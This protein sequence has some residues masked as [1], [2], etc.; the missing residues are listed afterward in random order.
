MEEGNARGG[1]PTGW[2][3]TQ[4]GN[5]CHSFFWIIQS[6]DID[7]TIIHFRLPKPFS[8]Q[9]WTTSSC[10][11]T[12]PQIRTMHCWTIQGHWVRFDL[13]LWDCL[14]NDYIPTKVFRLWPQPL[15]HWQQWKNHSSCDESTMEMAQSTI[16]LHPRTPKSLPLPDIPSPVR[17]SLNWKRVGSMSGNT[18]YS[19]AVSH[20]HVDE[21][22]FAHLHPHH[23][24]QFVNQKPVS[25][26][27]NVMSHMTKSNILSLFVV[28]LLIFLLCSSLYLVFRIGKSRLSS[29][30][31]KRM[32][33]S[34]FSLVFQIHFRNRLSQ[35]M[36]RQQDL[37][38]GREI[39][40]LMAWV[41]V[42]TKCKRSLTTMWSK[43]HRYLKLNHD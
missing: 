17:V 37:R 12:C 41:A 15:R 29:K 32:K 14:L 25:A 20:S 34:L 22:D 8:V 5:K 10:R 33:P 40:T 2:T 23:Q 28:V 13:L 35:G 16:K 19:F 39:L 4:C 21:A 6:C 1:G 36:A 3:D 24:Q 7:R 43:Y 18:K 27:T 38:S 11:T 30:Y 9:S 42:R 31:F 26:W